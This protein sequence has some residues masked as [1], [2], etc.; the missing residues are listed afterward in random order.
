MTQAEFA[1]RRGVSKKTV[2]VW[3]GNGL[4]VFGDDGLVDVDATEWNLDQRPAKYR[5]GVAHRPV[6]SAPE[7][8]PGSAAAKQK[9][10]QAPRSEPVSADEIRTDEGPYDPDDPNLDLPAAVR[11]KENFLGLQRKQAVEKEAGRLVE[12]AA[13]EALFFD[14]ARDLRDAWLSWPARIAIVMADELRVDPRALTTVLTAH[15]QQHLAELGEPEC[16]L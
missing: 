2:T 13:A 8:Q 11:R 10:G 1:R 15:V 6:R 12:R 3:K 5:G 14:T 7:L 16:Q 9:P 4:L